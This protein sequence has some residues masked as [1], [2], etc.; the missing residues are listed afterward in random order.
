MSEVKEKDVD[1]LFDGMATLLTNKEATPVFVLTVLI[2]LFQTIVNRNVLPKED[3]KQ[4][5]LAGMNAIKQQERMENE[6]MGITA[7]ELLKDE[8]QN[9]NLQGLE[10]KI[11]NAIIDS[12]EVEREKIKE[13]IRRKAE[14]EKNG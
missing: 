12:Y 8:N 13:K 3:V 5:L 4:I 14:E 10:N 9:L 2:Q 6:I 1:T 11:Y 7:K